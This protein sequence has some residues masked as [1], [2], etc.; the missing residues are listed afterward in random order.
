M[1]WFGMFGRRILCCGVALA[2]FAQFGGAHAS[3]FEVLYKFNPGSDGN[4]P[5]GALIRDNAGNLYG[6]A[7]AGGDTGC[8]NTLGCGTVFKLTPEGVESV[9]YAFK[10]R[11]DGADPSAGLV[12]DKSGNLYGTTQGSY[13][14]KGL[15]GGTVFKVAPDGTETVL[16][17]F[18]GA[19]DGLYPYAPLTLDR[20]GNLYGTTTMGG[21]YGGG[22][23]FEIAKDGRE[24]ILWSF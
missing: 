6:T 2:A 7:A 8:G 23:L 13:S 5:A 12:M 21:N 20:R 3:R 24:F 4:S 10:G 19:D 1:R 14:S 15:S 22:I 17:R 11:R 16:H 9:L 18:G